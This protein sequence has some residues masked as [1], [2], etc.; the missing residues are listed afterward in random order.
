MQIT[1]ATI[2]TA[3]FVYLLVASLQCSAIRTLNS[4]DEACFVVAKL[5]IVRFGSGDFEIRFE[6]RHTMSS[7]EGAILFKKSKKVPFF[8]G[9]KRKV[10]RND[11]DSDEL[12]SS[13]DE[14]VVVKKD[15]REAL[16]PL[17]QS[18]ASFNKKRAFRKNLGRDEQD[19]GEEE[20]LS[21]VSVV[22]KS[23]K[24]A[25]SLAPKDMGATAT[26]NVDTEKDRDAQAIFEKARKINEDQ[27]LDESNVYKGMN[28][29][30]QYVQKK[31]TALGNAS[32][33]LV[34]QGPVRAPDNLRSTIRWLVVLQLS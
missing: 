32:S 3:R 28:N 26:V 25:E 31:D 5:S 7:E 13:D 8:R 18:T 6:S 21:T 4:R 14:T 1:R 29:Y 2:R 20:R 16:N 34:R 24:T 30:K 27:D 12:S 23:D 10:E 17:V 15:R 22:Y 9:V 11:S 33:S 19:R